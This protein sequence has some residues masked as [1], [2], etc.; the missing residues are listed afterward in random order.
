MAALIRPCTITKCEL[1]SC[2]VC[3]CCQTDLCLEHLREHKEKLDTKLFPLGNEINSMT[4]YLEHFSPT[5]SPGFVA[6][7]EWRINAHRAIDACADKL[8]HRFFEEKRQ[9]SREKLNQS[10][11]FLNQLLRK[12]GAT[13][14]SINALTTSIAELQEQVN[15][16]KNPTIRLQPLVIVE[17]QVIAVEVPIA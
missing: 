16:L 10:R 13:Q 5:G 14:E 9:I 8:V 15:S 3:H 6:I 11:E 4:D 17:S 2:A 7:D 1:A 12:Q